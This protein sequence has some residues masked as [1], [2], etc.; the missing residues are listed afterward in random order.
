MKR[1]KCDHFWTIVLIKEYY[2]EFGYN[3]SKY[4]LYCPKCGKKKNRLSHGKALQLIN[5][6]REKLKYDSNCKH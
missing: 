1:N 4:Y 6:S 5:I 2:D 3:K